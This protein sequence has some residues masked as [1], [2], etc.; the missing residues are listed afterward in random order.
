MKRIHIVNPAAGQ[1]KCAELCRRYAQDGD[2][3]YETQYAGD[4]ADSVKRLLSEETDE[5]RLCVYGGDG[6]VSEAVNG[7]MEADAG[8][9]CVLTPVPGGTGNDFVRTLNEA[10]DGEHPADVISVRGDSGVR[11]AVNMLNAGFDAD[12]GAM[13]SE[14][15][16]K[17]LISG[18]FAYIVGVVYR[19]CQ[20]M[21]RPMKISWVDENGESHTYEDDILLCAVGN[22]R[23]CGGGFRATPC[24]DLSDGL[25]DL[26]IVRRVPRLKFLLLVKRYHDGTHIGPDGKPAKAFASVVQYHQCRSVQM[27]GMKVF[28]RDG[29]ISGDASVDIT[30]IPSALRCRS[31]KDL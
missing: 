29:E 10:E 12:V 4:V 15:K 22:A 19:L 26:L 23:Y 25:L 9:R 11:Y 24:A 28:C 5:V 16:K 2:T 6:S 1:G 14:L 20:R 7:V 17:P 18:S 8:T 21:G 3:V 13:I 31:A 27:S 30:L